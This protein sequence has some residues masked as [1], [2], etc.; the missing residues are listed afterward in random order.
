MSLISIAEEQFQA[1]KDK[2]VLVTGG[3]S[4]IGLV[5]IQLLISVGAK[6][7]NVDVADQRAPGGMD[8]AVYQFVKADVT[9]WNQLRAAFEH[10]ISVYGAIDHVFANA[11]EPKQ[12]YCR[13][14]ASRLAR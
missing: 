5:T 10:A 12:H 8:P 4:G 6:V 3:S 9:S 14:K 13:G 2:V 11:G 1:L 7:V